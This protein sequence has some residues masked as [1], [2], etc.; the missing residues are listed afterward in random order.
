MTS[1]LWLNW[2]N[3]DEFHLGF[4]KEPG[5]AGSAADGRQYDIVPGDAEASIM[6]YRTETEEV[7][8]MM[9]LIGRSVADDLAVDILRAWVDG[10]PAD[11]CSD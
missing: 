7:G 10:L 4:C 3:E 5:S 2:D 8:E 11:D 6:V 1:R 9:P